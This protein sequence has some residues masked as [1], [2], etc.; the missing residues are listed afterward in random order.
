MQ[1]CDYW[2]DFPNKKKFKRTRKKPR[3][4]TQ[5]NE[6]AIHWDHLCVWI[7]D[8]WIV[9]ESWG[10]WRVTPR[11]CTHIPITNFFVWCA[12]RVGK[13]W[14][15]SPPQLLDFHSQFLPI[16]FRTSPASEPSAFFKSLC[17]LDGEKDKNREQG[18]GK[19]GERE[20][21]ARQTGQSR[22]HMISAAAAD[23]RAAG[24][25][26]ADCDPKD[27]AGMVEDYVIEK[28]ED[29]SSQQKI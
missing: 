12:F 25:G 17:S 22:V 9:T 28:K 19:E 27:V 23:W 3:A 20:I 16:P 4:V 14:T 5:I 29:A 24:S 8:S 21:Q 15:P 7:A 18:G 2:K 6:D 1:R 11:T 26:G 13:T 10:Q